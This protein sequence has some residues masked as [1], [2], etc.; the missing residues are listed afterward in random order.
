MPGQVVQYP[1]WSKT[2]IPKISWRRHLPSHWGHLACSRPGAAVNMVK[3]HINVTVSSRNQHFCCFVSSWTQSIFF[4]ATFQWLLVVNPLNH[5]IGWEI[6]QETPIFDGKNHGFHHMF[7]HLNGAPRDTAHRCWA[8]RWR[9]LSP[10]APSRC[11]RPG[12]KP[13]ESRVWADVDLDILTYIYMY[14]YICIYIY[15]YIYMYIYIFT[16]TDMYRYNRCICICICICV[17][18][19]VIVCLFIYS[20]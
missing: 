6:L 13:G 12:P 4:V 9:K 11:P 14:I 17:Y 8:T 3:G 2:S 18:I 7:P 5:R 20:Y 16:Y 10:D 1:G 15:V 19:Y